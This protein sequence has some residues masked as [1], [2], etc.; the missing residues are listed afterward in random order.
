MWMMSMVEILF[1][2]SDVFPYGVLCRICRSWNVA[3][4]VD[5]NTGSWTIHQGRI[6]QASIRSCWLA[7][8]HSGTQGPNIVIYCD[9]LWS[10]VIQRNHD[11]VRHTVDMFHSFPVRIIVWF[12]KGIRQRAKCLFLCQECVSFV[13]VSVCLCVCGYMFVFQ[14]QAAVPA[15][16]N[17]MIKSSQMSHFCVNAAP[18]FAPRWTK[19]F[20]WGWGVAEIRS[21]TETPES[22]SLE[23]GFLSCFVFRLQGK[24][25]FSPT[26]NVLRYLTVL[27]EEVDID[28]NPPAR[29][30]ASKL[31]LSFRVSIPIQTGFSV[32]TMVGNMEFA[33]NSF[34]W[35]NR[36]V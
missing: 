12:K 33:L 18:I 36:L 4:N 32:N 1:F 8:C 15:W 5:P 19:A 14:C 21:K 20:L 35:R 10:F 27:V 22:A 17:Q 31:P 3:W 2:S 11:R 34:L 9:I 24:C 25:R 16:I 7:G 29:R 28:A 30:R 26:W 23:F 13:S 6:L